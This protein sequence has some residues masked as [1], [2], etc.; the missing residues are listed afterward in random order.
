M[1]LIDKKLSAL[2]AGDRVCFT[3]K[4][5]QMLTGVIVENDGKETL[6]VQVTAL[7]T[8]KYEQISMIEENAVRAFEPIVSQVTQPT[9]SLHIPEVVEKPEIV[10]AE[11][12]CEKDAVLNSFKGMNQEERKILT[13]SYDKCQSFFKS[14]EMEK[15]R[16]ASRLIWSIMGKNDW[17]YNPRVNRYYAYVQLV[18]EEDVNASI[19]FFYAKDTRSAYLSAY[20]GALKKS[21]AESKELYRLAAAF[22][23]VYMTEGPSVYFT[24]AAEVL[25]K[26]CAETKDISGVLYMLKQNRSQETEEMIL[27]VLKSIGDE[28]AQ[29]IDKIEDFEKCLPII[30]LRYPMDDVEKEINEHISK[31]ERENESHQTPQTNITETI[32][33]ADSAVVY[34]IVPELGKVYSG[35]VVAYNFFEDRGKIEAEDGLKYAFELKDVQDVSLKTQ[36]KKLPKKFEPISVIFQFSKRISQFVAIAVKRGLEVKKAPEPETEPVPTK[37]SNLSADSDKIEDAKALYSEKR[38]EDAIKVYEK[39]LD[40][41]RWEDAFSQIIMCYLALWNA[42]GDDEGIYQK[43]LD[44]LVSDHSDKTFEQQKT[45]EMLYQYYMKVQNYLECIR[46]LNKLIES[47]GSDEHGRLLHYLTGKEHCYR[48]LK[49]YP[50][51]ISQLLDWLDIVKRNKMSDRYKQRDN[52]IY[53]ELAEVYFENGEYENAEKYAKLAFSSERKRDLLKEIEKI[54]KKQSEEKNLHDNEELDEDIQDDE[55]EQ[56]FITEESAETIRE[57]FESYQDVDGFDAL[58]LSDEDIFHH[59][60]AFPQE[61]LDC[62]LTYLKASALLAGTSQNEQFAHTIPAVEKVF[63]YA[64]NSPLSENSYLSPEIITAFQETSTLIPELNDKL[65]VATSMMALFNHSEVMDYT[66]EDLR[67]LA[68][69]SAISESFPTMVNLLEE[70]CN[71]RMMT[72]YGMDSFADYKTSDTVIE[73]IIAEAKSCADVVDMKNVVYE[74]QGQVRR[75]RELMFNAEYSD[76]RKSLDI[77]IANDISHF[78]YVKNFISEQFIRSGRPVSAENIEG[79]KIDK[80]IDYFWDEARDLIQSEKR[81]ISRPHDKI[82]GSK[83]NNVVLN[84]KKMVVCICDWLSVAEHFTTNDNV[85]AKDKYA[86]VAPRVKEYLNGVLETCTNL[87]NEKG[88]D[89][90]MEAIRRM[91]QELLEKMNGT[92]DSRTRKYL[93]INFLAGEEILLNERYLPELQS[94]FCAWKDFNILYRIEYHASHKHLSWS[95]RISEILSE[96]ESKHNFRSAMLIKSYGE[97]MGLKEIANHKDFEQFNDCLKQAKQRFDTLYHDFNDE[98]ELYESYGTLSDMNGEKTAILNLTLDWYRITRLTSDFGFYVRMLDVIRNRIASNAAEKGERLLK[99]LDELSD[100]PEYDFG[101]YPK[102][103]IAS[104]IQD[105]NYTVAEY[106]LNCIRRHDTK[107]LAMNYTTDPFSYFAGFMNEYATNYRVSFDAKINIELAIT[108]YVGKKNLELAMKHLTNNAMKDVRGGCNLIHNWTGIS[109]GADRIEKALNSLGFTGCQV[110][111]DTGNGEES[112]IVYRKKQ[113]GKINYPHPIPAFS[114]LAEEEGFRVLCLYGRFDCNRLMDMFRTVNTAAKHTI[115]FLDYALNQDERRK[116]AR[117]I[118]EEKS[119]AKCFIVVDRVVLLYLAKH[120]ASNTVNKMLM[121]ITMPFAYYQPFV[122]SSNQT[123]PPELFTGREA[124]LT[125]IESADGANLVYGGRQLG[126]SALLKMAQHNIDGNANGD[127]ALLV[128]VLGLHYTDVA[129]VV[130]NELV[131][132][133]I[134][135]ESCRCDD[136]DILAGHLKKR[137]M[138]D[139]PET[140]INYLLLMLDEADKFISTSVEDGNRPIAALKNLPSNRFKLVMAGLHNLSRYNREEM[141]H[142]NSNLV[143]LNSVIVRPFQ[144]PEAVKLLTHTLAYLG[145]RFNENVISL[146]LAKTNYF[147]GLIQLYCQKLLEAM[148]NDD[149]AGYSEIN[150]PSYEVTESHFKKVLSDKDF[151]AKVKE[152][153]EITIFVEGK[154]RTNYHAIALILAYLYYTSSSDDGYTLDE[155]LA[156]ANEYNITRIISLKREQ[157][158]ELLNEMWDLNVLSAEG[159]HY[160]FA[161]EG[162]REMLGSREEVDEAMSKYYFEGGETE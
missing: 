10:I 12:T 61:R 94:T 147:P 133:G 65:L 64:F 102:K 118:K 141:L 108:K 67:E 151:M 144:R 149:Y 87:T 75:M 29:K 71:F 46:L 66:I 95:E 83:R 91:A 24:E 104:F 1:N 138:D 41:E 135:D 43:A 32:E 73:K 42:N 77:V 99:Q 88:F 7:A 137:L 11:I 86:E 59:A 79:K 136:W 148:K 156:V 112:Y 162:F 114:S 70:L 132:A 82:K 28:C 13:S 20:Q 116:L 35:K 26:A 60:L 78:Q 47:C 27:D 152:K 128:E 49:D 159:D 106:M 18:L 158:E 92:Y 23:A 50:S 96:I 150:T 40:G 103:T 145:F 45:L 52:L 154:G 115:V 30:K 120:Y 113:T 84:V 160:R 126:K 22:S 8:L 101:V 25:K 131:I 72:G 53:I 76:L 129:K 39:N 109:G 48:V 111:P 33:S 5:G 130:S 37:V 68:E 125:S 110:S 157:V 134:L 63:S 93:F 31:L 21:I 119:F 117:K 58:E 121:A 57:A 19:S 15:C 74:S 38:Y 127:R 153:L 140:R 62:L 97:D 16:E 100:K 44:E 122:E 139:N 55:P 142:G 54:K 9:I 90:G 17:Y 98:L 4:N 51:A 105:Q 161:T 107:D 69:N 3:Q 6:S 155:I 143:H 81:H 2:K 124:E 85:F 34:P 56:E 89:W 146:I 36:L 14:H 123:M 80:F